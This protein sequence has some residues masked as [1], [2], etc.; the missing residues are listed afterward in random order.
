VYACD[1]EAMS[2]TWTQLR[3]IFPEEPEALGEELKD[4]FDYWMTVGDDARKSALATMGDEYVPPAGSNR[5]EEKSR[6]LVL[7]R[8]PR[9][10]EQELPWNE[11]IAEWYG[12]LA[13]KDGV[14]PLR[15]LPRTIPSTPVGGG[16]AI[17]QED[18]MAL[19]QRVSRI[20]AENATLKSEVVAMRQSQM[21]A[22]TP[23]CAYEV[24]ED[25]VELIPTSF[26]DRKPMEA[27]DRT[28]I[29]RAWCGK[30]ESVP[31][32][33]SADGFWK[34]SASVQQH[35]VPL[36]E[37]VNTHLSDFVGRNE[38]PLRLSAT[39][40]SRVKDITDG[41]DE[42]LASSRDDPDCEAPYDMSIDEVM[43]P[44]QVIRD[45]AVA[46][47]E[48]TAD[49]SQFLFSRGQE[50]VVKAGGKDVA[51]AF[52]KPST[53]TESL[54][55]SDSLILIKEFND[56]KSDFQKV[57]KVQQPKP[58]PFSQQPTSKSTGNG[59]NWRSKYPKGGSK[60]GRGGKGGGS[61]GG[62]GRGGG[63]RGSGSK[64]GGSSSS[65]NASPAR[66]DPGAGTN[67]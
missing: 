6:D 2:S 59:G 27:K 37:F 24:R 63:G 26:R 39:L 14:V 1:R 66:S 54:M 53:R 65:R 64:G 61:R 9:S 55:P 16:L 7:A 19:V 33:P 48:S 17:S 45:T 21:D 46:L 36:L 47:V 67:P 35:K 56:K 5:K 8:V 50:L 62:G 34:E 23:V 31:A 15:E 3:E 40:L 22:F 10:D 12:P 25:V 44:L 60:G 43:E 32:R 4:L 38:L 52:A 57:M 41:I 18:L 11:E 58:K 13:S 29:Q 42:L 20:E 28:R 30:L 49:T 51:A